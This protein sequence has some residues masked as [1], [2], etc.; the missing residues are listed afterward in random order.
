MKESLFTVLSISGSGLGRE[1]RNVASS[2]LLILSF[3]DLIS[4]F[5]TV[6]CVLSIHLY[7]DAHTGTGAR[8]WLLTVMLSF[9]ITHAS[10]HTVCVVWEAIVPRVYGAIKQ[11]EPLQY[12]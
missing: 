7:S 12:H 2:S 11:R 3:L 1:F 8:D 10:P 5:F 4:S 9:Q 6:S